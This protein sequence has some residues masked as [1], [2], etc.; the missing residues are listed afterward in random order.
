MK[1]SWNRALNGNPTPDSQA[2]E[3]AAFPPSDRAVL[4][5]SYA[6]LE[7][8]EA[9]PLAM[10]PRASQLWT[11]RFES[12]LDRFGVR[13]GKTKEAMTDVGR[14]LAA[15]GR[16]AP[17][18]SIC[19][20]PLRLALTEDV[21]RASEAA[22]CVESSLVRAMEWARRVGALGAQGDAATEMGDSVADGGRPADA[23]ALVRRSLL[24]CEAWGPDDSSANNDEKVFLRGQLGLYGFLM[25]Q[26]ICAA[27]ETEG[28]HDTREKVEAEA[29]SP[30]P[31]DHAFWTAYAGTAHLWGTLERAVV[32]PFLR[33]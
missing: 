25:A 27:V 32:R 29:D 5:L 10:S 6:D 19:A 16:I 2:S 22:E 3:A 17:G 1:R 31:S 13:R 8:L 24:L 4:A 30:L 33:V 21:W 15:I 14:G 18:E 9:V 23:H 11:D 26:R 7:H 28:V 20:L 12:H